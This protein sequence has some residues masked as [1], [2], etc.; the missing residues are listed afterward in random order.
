MNHQPRVAIGLPVYNG[1]KYLT[2]AL[3]AILAQT[4]SDFALLISDNASTDRTQEICLAYAAKDSRIRYFRNEINVGSA[5]N[6]NRVFDLSISEYFMWAAHDDIMAP[7]LVARCVE[8]LERDPSVVLCHALVKII[9]EQGQVIADYDDALTLHHIG[10]DRPSERFKDLIMIPHYCFDSYGLIRAS[11]LTMRPLF[12]GYVGSDRN[13]LAE[14]GL[15]G[16]FYHIPEAL[17]FNRDHPR[18]HWPLWMWV[19]QFDTARVSQ[20]PFPRWS[21]LGGYFKSIRRA[22]LPARERL[23]CYWLVCAWT[24]RNARG[25]AKD[26]VVAATILLKRLRKA[27]KKA[28]GLAQSWS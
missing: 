17:F 27:P 7:T 25:L 24:P 6:F 2:N 3:D 21:L 5:P 28:P 26:L 18:R 20:I 1:E 19:A 14:L 8:V 4:Y 23:R 10:S 16:K 15:L 9:D 22:P 11:A 13:F 12:D